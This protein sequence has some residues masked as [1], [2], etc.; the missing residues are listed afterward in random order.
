MRS[1]VE[2]RRASSGAVA[3]SSFLF[4]RYFLLHKG[5]QNNKLP[6]L[7]SRLAECDRGVGCWVVLSCGRAGLR[8]V[9]V[10]TAT[11]CIHIHTPKSFMAQPVFFLC[12]RSTN[13]LTVQKTGKLA[14][15]VARGPASVNPI[16]MLTVH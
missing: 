4:V 8:D 10:P 16:I 2:I 5:R 3:A 15:D 6:A 7:V 12:C 11:L 9:V 1:F 13:L 14:F